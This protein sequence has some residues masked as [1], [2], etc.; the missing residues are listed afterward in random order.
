[1]MVALLVV[2]IL[3]LLALLIW[4]VSERPPLPPPIDSEEA[5]HAAVELH[6]I[7][8]N[9]DAS[10]AKSELRRESD[11]LRRQLADELERQ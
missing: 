5:M 9:L 2:L 11:R 10:L 4:T 8:R 1:M 6:R 7:R 3:F